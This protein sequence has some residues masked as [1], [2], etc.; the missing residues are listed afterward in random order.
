VDV[1]VAT[2]PPAAQLDPRLL[3]RIRQLNR[4]DVRLYEL[5]RER[6]AAAG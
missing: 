3:E 1:P 5:A 4:L 6:L 2:P